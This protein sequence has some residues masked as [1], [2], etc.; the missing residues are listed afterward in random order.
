[1]GVK[2]N[3]RGESTLMHPPARPP[4]PRCAST[5]CF[6]ERMTCP[7]LP[8]PLL[9]F[10]PISIDVVALKRGG[11]RGQA[12]IVYADQASAT[13]AL[14]GLDGEEFYGKALVRVDATELILV[15][16]PAHALLT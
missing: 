15:A 13:S 5:H 6:L 8:L 3:R 11:M 7:A 14:K 12:F 2:P 9:A 1:M 4:R 10:G 16:D